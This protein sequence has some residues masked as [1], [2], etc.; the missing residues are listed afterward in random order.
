MTLIKKKTSKWI[1]FIGIGIL[2]LVVG[3]I[4]RWQLIDRHKEIQQIESKLGFDIK[5]VNRQSNGTL[6]DISRTYIVKPLKDDKEKGIEY[7]LYL[8]KD[9]KIEQW[10]KRKNGKIIGNHI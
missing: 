6:W 5:V 4:T 3:G 10:A 1:I 8:N 7:I 2:L 9:N